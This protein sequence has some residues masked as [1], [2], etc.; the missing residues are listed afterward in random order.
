VNSLSNVYQTGRETHLLQQESALDHR[1]GIIPA[2]SD[3]ADNHKSRLLLAGRSQ[4]V[5]ESVFGRGAKAAPTL[6]GG[7]YFGS[8]GTEL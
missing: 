6:R 4:L 7:A 2:M 3:I 1:L 5:A 8:R